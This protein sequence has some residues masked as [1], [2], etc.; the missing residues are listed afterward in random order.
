MTL[1]NLR[2]WA[3][4]QA[5]AANDIK[6]DDKKRKIADEAATIRETQRI[7]RV[8][9]VGS[10][11]QLT[12]AGFQAKSLGDDLSTAQRIA[13]NNSLFEKTQRERPSA[14]P[15]RVRAAANVGRALHFFLRG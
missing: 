4:E 9:P 5:I 8:V 10:T 1:E 11:L 14:P 13:A 15:M 6:G 12:A 3:K 7:A 2:N